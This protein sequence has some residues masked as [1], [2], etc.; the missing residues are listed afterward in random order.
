MLSYAHANRGGWANPA[1]VDL[2]AETA[3]VIPDIAIE[4]GVGR[5]FPAGLRAKHQPLPHGCPLT[6]VCDGRRP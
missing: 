2:L 3:N 5:G 1:R 6:A 4:P